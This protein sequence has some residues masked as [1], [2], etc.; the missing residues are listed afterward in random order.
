MNS[1][2]EFAVTGTNS[3]LASAVS[4][5]LPNYKLLPSA[6]SQ[7]MSWAEVVNQKTELWPTQ[8][9]MPGGAYIH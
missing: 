3:T 2:G 5:T 7:A 9:L 6:S 8:Y 4:E 1:R